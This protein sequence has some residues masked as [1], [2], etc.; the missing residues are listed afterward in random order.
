MQIRGKITGPLT[1]KNL[2][3]L[4]TLQKKDKPL[5]WPRWRPR[6]Q[7]HYKK[8]GFSCSRCDWSLISYR[9]T[10]V[11]KAAVETSQSACSKADAQRLRPDVESFRWCQYQDQQPSGMDGDNTFPVIPPELR[12]LVPFDSGDVLLHSILMICVGLSAKSSHI[13]GN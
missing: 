6:I 2:I 13:I 1:K 8:W 5:L 7:V 3:I 4:D 12:P 10:F 9:L 11:I